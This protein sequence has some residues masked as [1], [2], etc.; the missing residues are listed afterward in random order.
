MQSYTGIRTLLGIFLFL[1]TTYDLKDTNKWKSLR[2]PITG[3]PPPLSPK[4]S[5]ADKWPKVYFVQKNFKMKSELSW[6]TRKIYFSGK[7]KVS[8]GPSRSLCNRTWERAI[9]RQARLFL[10]PEL[11]VS[12]LAWVAK[13]ALAIRIERWLRKQAGRVWTW[14]KVQILLIMFL[15]ALN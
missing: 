6:K 7:K 5:E 13:E 14:C 11:R 3:H 2:C 8:N 10:G 4:W 12:T 15:S 1:P 9:E